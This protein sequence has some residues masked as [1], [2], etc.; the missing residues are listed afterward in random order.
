MTIIIINNNNKLVRM[1]LILSKNTMNRLI[2]RYKAAKLNYKKR[3]N[4]IRL[5]PKCKNSIFSGSF[6]I[7]NT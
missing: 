7:S 6:S 3:A 4:W 1:N 2:I 5:N